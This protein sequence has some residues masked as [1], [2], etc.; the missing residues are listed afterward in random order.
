MDIYE[1]DKIHLKAM[2]S[3]YNIEV[4]EK[5]Q[6]VIDS[7]NL[8]LAV[9][10]ESQLEDELKS[11]V[12]EAR[13]RKDT[14][15]VFVVNNEPMLKHALQFVEDR[16][17]SA[18]ATQTMVYIIARSY[19]FYAFYFN[20]GMRSY[21]L[22]N[23]EFI[24]AI[25]TTL[26]TLI[27]VSARKSYIA[28]RPEDMS[29]IKIICTIFALYCILGLKSK[30]EILKALSHLELGAFN[31][32]R[33]LLFYNHFTKLSKGSK[34]IAHIL[35]ELQNWNKVAQDTLIINITRILGPTLT[36]ILMTC[37]SFQDELITF[38]W[39]MS[40]LYFYYKIGIIHKEANVASLNKLTQFEFSRILKNL[41]KF[42]R[43]I[44]FGRC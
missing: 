43:M 21:A 26:I 17:V 36:K 5:I 42:T 37:D 7:Y 1:L 20:K 38:A 39:K 31:K 34:S 23:T 41:E 3:S 32:L 18:S 10:H 40:N 16:A 6:C 35:G 13:V 27:A 22:G 11:L 29:D 33:V 8:K 28:L 4:P 14:M 19:Y 15:I 24:R 44:H 12:D 25:V 30:S 9:L 2:I